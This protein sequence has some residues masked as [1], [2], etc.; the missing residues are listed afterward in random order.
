MNPQRLEIEQVVHTVSMQDSRWRRDQHAVG[1]ALPWR[2][3]CGGQQQCMAM[4]RAVP[5]RAP[6]AQAGINSWLPAA[7]SLISP[8]ARRRAA[9]GTGTA[10]HITGVRPSLPS[11]PGTALMPS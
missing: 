3:L 2:G 4:A 8:H 11:R 6:T 7:R 9:G 5:A 1:R 10:P